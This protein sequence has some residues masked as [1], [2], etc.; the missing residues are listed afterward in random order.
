MMNKIFVLLALITLSISSEAQKLYKIV[1][2]D[3]NVSFSQYPPAE[4]KEDVTVSDIAVSGGSKSSVTEELD[5]KYCG[6]IKL[7]SQR[8]SSYSVERHVKNVD[9]QRDS[10]RKQLDQLSKRIDD[11]N[12]RAIDNNSSR[13]RSAS[14]NKYYQDSITANGEKLRDLRCALDWADEE[15][16]GTSDV[17]ATNKQERERLEK[18]KLDLEAKLDKRCG[19]LPAYDPSARR[20]ASLRSNWYE[21]SDKLR[22]D[23]EKVN[24][25]IRKI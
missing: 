18:I 23:I 10:W 15:L 4:K 14:S 12:Q 17:V 9:R 8:S 22:G 25:A 2:E 7:Y 19:E 20:N 16:K 21:C 13:Y 1:D 6:K 11:A 3:G 24:R 5:G